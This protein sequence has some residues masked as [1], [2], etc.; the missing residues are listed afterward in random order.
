MFF[1]TIDQC[2]Q[3]ADLLAKSGVRVDVITGKTDRDKQLN[4]FDQNE[5]DV[6]VNV[7]V[8]T[9]GF[10]CPNLRSVF[11]RPSSKMPTIQMTGRVLRKHE[12]ISWVNIIQSQETKYPFTRT[13]SAERQFVRIDDEWRS[14]RADSKRIKETACKALMAIA[15]TKIFLPPLVLKNNII[16]KQTYWGWGGD[17][18]V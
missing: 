14:I 17:I 12:D 18:D 7:Y 4:A 1:H 6:I 2:Y 13:A 11:V 5:L 15:T 10:D 9:E 8:L 3:T 16:K